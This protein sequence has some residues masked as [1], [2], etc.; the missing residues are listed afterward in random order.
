MI[1]SK[2]KVN[3]LL[4]L[5]LFL[6]ILLANL[7]MGI[8]IKYLVTFSNEN[9]IFYITGLYS[10]IMLSLLFCF[11]RNQSLSTIGINKK[12]FWK[13]LIIGLIISIII[14]ILSGVTAILNISVIQENIKLILMEIIY[15]FVF[16]AFTEEILF[17][18]YIGSR[19]FI[20]RRWL[21]NVI[22]GFMFAFAHF[23][24]QAVIQ[25]I[26]FMNYIMD[27]WFWVFSTIILHTLLQLFYS[28]YNNF[29]GPTLIHFSLDFFGWLVL[30]K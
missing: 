20:Y 2:L 15:Y 13:S 25:Q 1:I 30:L 21:T 12:N 8:I 16:I 26:N 28:K 27:N 14:A 22:V 7:L 23:P 29:I 18:G 4:P 19:L 5:I 9:M 11:I 24:F 3:K 10:F 17:R 6:I